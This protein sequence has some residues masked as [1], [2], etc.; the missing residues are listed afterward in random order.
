MVLGGEPDIEIVGEASDG[1]SAIELARR[2]HPDV[3]TMDV[4]LPG[5]NGIEATRAIHAE[6]PEVSVIGLSMF[7]DQGEA[8]REAGAV[9]YLIK[10]GASSNLLAAIRRACRKTPT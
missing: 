2:L 7:E 5:I 1:H 4:G 9:G 10:T 6:L 8:M 3:V